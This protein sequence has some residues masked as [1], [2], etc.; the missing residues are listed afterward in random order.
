[1]S[2]YPH[3][4]L[5]LK[6]GAMS[7]SIALAL[8]VFP[9]ILSAPAAHAE[10]PAAEQVLAG[11]GLKKVGSYWILPG[12]QEL[13]DRLKA[14]APKQREL[15]AALTQR[16]RYEKER[17]Q[18][19]AALQSAIAER[20][21]VSYAVYQAEDERDL[22]ALGARLAAMTDRIN[23]MMRYLS[24]DRE[25][26]R[27]KER[28][29]AAGAALYGELQELRKLADETQ[30]R[31]IA[32]AADAEVGSAVAALAADA[33][34]KL[35]LGPRKVFERNVAELARYE[36]A[37][38]S[39]EIKLRED[40]GVFWIDAII[41]GKAGVEMVFDTGASMVSLPESAARQAGIEPS[42]NDPVVQLS[43]AD[44]RIVEGHLVFLDELRVGAFSVQKVEA[45]IVPGDAPPLLGGTFLQHFSI[46]LNHSAGTLRLTSISAPQAAKRS[47]D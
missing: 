12:E 46:D 16:S 21:R 43:V 45:V 26:D 19:Q 4:P 32:L 2:D 17:A 34:R 41:N 13:E 23:A 18:Q 35:K 15:D 14:L 42:D 8:L 7:R 5:L 1:M 24:E 47:R 25:A 33:A 36:A 38:H 37:I 44:G 31:Y 28:V 3:D 20:Q 40:H 9:L 6:G 39:E 30:Q 29:G 10:P 11:K 27:I 22:R